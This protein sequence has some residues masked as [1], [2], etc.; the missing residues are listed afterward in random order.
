MGRQARADR[1][2][3][4]R[5]LAS[6][7]HLTPGPPRARVAGFLLLAA[8]AAARATAL[9][10]SRGSR[11]VS[12]VLGAGSL[13]PT[14]QHGWCAKEFTGKLET[15][16]GGR[17]GRRGLRGFP[18]A[19]GAFQPRGPSRRVTARRAAPGGA[20]TEEAGAAHP[21]RGKQTRAAPAWGGA[22]PHSAPGPA[23]SAPPGASARRGRSGLAPAANENGG[24]LVRSPVRLTI[25]RR[26][27][28]GPPNLRDLSQSRGGG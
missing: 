20:A 12:T 23:G 22:R 5:A 17:S 15:G 24:L 13:L 10:V 6:V 14:A 4:M 3:A 2:A 21:E 19:W 9:Q 1:L 27:G 7:F 26:P 8:S 18:R 28:L 16:K 11:Q 25:G